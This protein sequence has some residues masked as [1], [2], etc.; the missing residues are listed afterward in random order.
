M[1]VSRIMFCLSNQMKISRVFFG[2]F[3]LLL[4]WLCRQIHIL[5]FQNLNET[6]KKTLSN[7]AGW[8]HKSYMLRGILEAV[9]LVFF[10]FEEHKG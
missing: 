8:S 2:H 4:V 1:Q 7:L 9:R 6:R 10:F 3:Q 5:F